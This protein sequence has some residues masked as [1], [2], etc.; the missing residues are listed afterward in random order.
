MIRFN[1]STTTIQVHDLRGR[2]SNLMNDLEEI[3]KT[4]IHLDLSFITLT[5]TFAGRLFIPRDLLPLAT[6][7]K[8]RSHFE[9]RN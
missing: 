1:D 4:L 2:R 8:K 9:K 7:G 5:H 6:A 3:Q